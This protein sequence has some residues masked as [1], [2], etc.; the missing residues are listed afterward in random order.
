MAQFF[1]DRPIFAWVIALFIL[2]MGGVAIKQL[3]IAQYPTVAPPAIVLTATYPGA[4]A[5]TLEDSVI[6]VIEQEMNGSPGLIY[7]ESTSQ[8]N[9]VGQLTMTFQTG[10]NP[11]LAQVDVQNRLS[12]AAPR[13]PAAVTQQGVRVDKARS[14][15]LLF[16]ILSSSN[17]AF[18]PIALGDY[19]SRTV[20]PEIQRLPGVGQAQLFGTERAMRIWIDP[21][22]LVGYNLSTN[23]VVAAIRAQNAQVSSGTIGDL[24]IVAGQPINATVV[25]AGQ[26][27]SVDQFGAIVL[28]ANTDGSTVKLADVARVELGG[29]NYATSARLNGKPST[30]IGVQLSPTG[31]ALATAELIRTRME[32]LSRYFPPGVKYD[33]PYD[34]SR[35][36]KIS[37]S[38]VVETLVEAVILVFLVMYLF[39]QS[40][41]Y[42]LI[43][44][45]VV[46]VALFGA[47]AVMQ[48]FGY[49]INVL[50]MFAMVL[51][52]GILVDDAIVVIENVERIMSE[53]GL[54]PREAT[55]KAM[56]QITTALVGISVTLVSVFLP[57][58]FFAGSVGNIYRQFSLVMVSSMLFSVFLALSLT[59]A[60]C[61]TFL[62][63]VEAGHKH[64]K[65]GF[66]GWFN[67]GFKATTHGYEGWVAKI[68]R[69]TGRFLILFALIVGLTVFMF[70]RMPSSF[71][72]TEDQGYLIANVQLP[73][74]ASQGRTLA[75]MQQAES[76]FLSQ[77]EVSQMVSVLGFSFSGSG[78]NAAL[79]FVTLKPW[80]EREGPAHSAQGIAGRA[81]GALSKVRDAFI[82]ALVPP[83]I[84]EL[85][86][87]TGF[88]F[89]LQDRGGNGHAALLA[90]RNQM[91]G[92]AGQS[93]V[94]AGVRPDGLEDAPQLQVDIDRD[95]ASALGVSFD[96]I[97]AALS[98]ALGSTYVND[99]PNAGRLQRVVVQA[100]APERMQP[101]DLLQINVLGNQGKPVPM[102]AFA[103]TRWIT[104]PIQTIRFN[105]YPTMRIS[106]DAAPG[107]STGDAMAE[108]ERL[109]SQLPPG[110][111]FEWTGQSREERLSGATATIL[112]GFS[113]LAVFLCLSALYESWSIPFSV[114]LAVPLGV[115]GAVLGASFRDMPNDVFFKVGLITVIGLSAKNAILIIEFAKD[116][117]AQG[118]DLV[119]AT[120]EA[121]HLR[122]RPIL[123]TSIAF[124]L[125]VLPLVVSTGAGSAS[126]R[127]IGT[128]VM[129]G[130]ITATVLAVFFVPVFFVVVRRVFKGSDRQRK[131]YAH[132]MDGPAKP[133]AATGASHD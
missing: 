58:A 26:L 122:F 41:R 29:Q 54:P 116:L 89:R 39:L 109:A 67:R 15:F 95:R 9:G 85:G 121:V 44:T 48:A 79:A 36:V 38:R 28:R 114:L 11:D 74:G 101:D 82:F 94:L 16:T 120:L 83:A 34:S 96:A 18:D 6:S 66:F 22:K 133:A 40:L 104:G 52:V 13:L 33:I 31:N 5:Q 76:F 62:K 14:N 56:G 53:E 103:T 128:G 30:G 4:S 64:E 69:R 61:A 73:P 91:L 42:T 10:T 21:A 88:S 55:K 60:L 70:L 8:A 43:P 46:P 86:T 100:D 49:S 98:T 124:I 117:H 108:M 7:M 68:L 65:R 129:S 50:T 113:L 23:D 77:P 20:L 80:D 115:L 3:P 72:P 45:V 125:G 81:F 1:I 37:I 19:A 25:V 99:F 57:M 17:P 102:A 35:F 51:A 126:Q 24:P 84:P 92:M 131:M 47:F 63:P 132:E 90:A 106:G 32:E 12:R 118:K 59:P 111:A 123:M 27:T 93:K 112:L 97:N 127:A 78:Q 87:A 105:G 2:V 75:V 110:F 71:L 107:Y 130:M 119:Q